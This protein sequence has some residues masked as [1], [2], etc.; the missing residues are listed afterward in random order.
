MDDIDDLEASSSGVQLGLIQK[1]RNVLFKSKV[2]KNWDGGK[3]GG[4]P[5]WL[6][7]SSF[8]SESE[9]QCPFCQRSLAF[10]MQVGGISIVD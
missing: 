5:I 8:P 6:D 2:W 9:L 1:E 4:D 10:L 3:V 7:P